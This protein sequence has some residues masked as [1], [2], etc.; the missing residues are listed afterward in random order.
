[1]IGSPWR[2]PLEREGAEVGAV[3][4]QPLTVHQA[5]P[6]ASATPVLG[7]L[8]TPGSDSGEDGTIFLGGWAAWLSVPEE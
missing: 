8:A 4:E 1:M 6:S 3:T 5:F 2:T 7:S